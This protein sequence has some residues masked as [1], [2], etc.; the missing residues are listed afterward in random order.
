M[1]QSDARLCNAKS[2]AGLNHV[3]HLLHALL[4]GGVRNDGGIGEEEQAR[5]AGQFGGGDVREQ[6]A[7]RQYALLFMEHG[8]EERVGVDKPLHQQ[9]GLATLGHGHGG[10]GSGFVAVG[11]NDVEEGIASYLAGQVF[12]IKV[13]RNKKPGL[14]K[15]FGCAAHE[16]LKCGAVG[17]AHHC[18]AP[19]PPHGFKRGGK[20]GEIQNGLHKNKGGNKSL[21]K[22]VQGECNQVYLNCRAAANLLQR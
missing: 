21:A 5:V 8:S 6:P 18:H 3:S 12:K 19:P 16:G 22:I 4:V 11:R 2:V 7:A 9:V 15:T 20:R 10:A 13:F 17:A 14:N 1:D